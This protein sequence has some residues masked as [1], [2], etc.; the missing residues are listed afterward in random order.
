[1]TRTSPHERWQKHILERFIALQQ[2]RQLDRLRKK[3]LS[4]LGRRRKRFTGKEW[5]ESLRMRISSPEYMEWYNECTEIGRRFGLNPQ[6][7]VYSCLI[8]GYDPTKEPFPMEVQWPRTRV[9]T[10]NTDPLFL[11]WLSYEAWRL[12]LY[13]VLHQGSSEATLLGTNMPPPMSLCNAKKPPRDT[14]LYLR[15]ET[16]PG[17]PPEAAKKLQRE[18]SQLTKE[19]LRS[20]GY[21][22][23][24]RLRSSPLIEIADSLKV[25]KDELANGEAYAII[26]DIYGED[27][28]D[29][30]KR[31]KLIAS[32]RNK[33]RKKLIEPYE[34]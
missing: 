7:V 9:V 20:L 2:S 25:S 13:V 12:G 16:P 17:Y 18:A 30:K 32:R 26:D 11:Q 31:R 19:L 22:I 6:T 34:P 21:S 14:A 24:Q 27:L 1:M 23:P 8:R 15:V 10:E 29:D 3:G 33:L 4:I 28:T 5:Y